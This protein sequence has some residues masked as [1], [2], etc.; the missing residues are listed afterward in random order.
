MDIRHGTVQFFSDLM[1]MHKR[2]AVFYKDQILH[3]VIED[4][5]NHLYF[6]LC[7]YSVQTLY[8][9]YTCACKH[10]GN[11]FTLLRCDFI[12]SIIVVRALLIFPRKIAK[13]VGWVSRLPI[14]GQETRLH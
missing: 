6:I 1:G 9:E 5:H 7:F 13:G 2:P 11:R 3:G 14:C 12:S 10:L 4:I 8:K